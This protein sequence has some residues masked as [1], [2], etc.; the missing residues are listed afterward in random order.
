MKEVDEKINDLTSSFPKKNIKKGVKN[1][2]IK[3]A[4]KIAEESFGYSF[5]K[6]LELDVYEGIELIR[7]VTENANMIEKE[8]NMQKE[9]EDSNGFQKVIKRA[10]KKI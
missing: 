10:N 7:L 5:D 8:K 9:I 2:K 6:V 3:D 1:M 4:L